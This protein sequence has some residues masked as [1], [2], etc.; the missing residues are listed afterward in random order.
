MRK[1]LSDE[2]K[3]EY[4]R[5]NGARCPHCKSHGIKSHFS[6]GESGFALYDV[7]CLDCKAEWCETFKLASVYGSEED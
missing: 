2:A 7:E 4:M 5:C 1:P 6:Y 3:A